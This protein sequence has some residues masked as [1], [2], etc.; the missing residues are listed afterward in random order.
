MSKQK[1]NYLIAGAQDDPRELAKEYFK[2]QASL[3]FQEVFIEMPDGT[4]SILNR[5]EFQPET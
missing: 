5:E 3:G 2:S 1:D 4:I